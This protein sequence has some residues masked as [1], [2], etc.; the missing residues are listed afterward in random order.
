MRYR[1]RMNITLCP[2]I[3]AMVEL[4]ARLEGLSVSQV[5]DAALAKYIRRKRP[6]LAQ[7][8]IDKQ[9]YERGGKL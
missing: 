9:K 3:K 7:T 6:A 8:Y 4:F 5:I 2:Q 1:T